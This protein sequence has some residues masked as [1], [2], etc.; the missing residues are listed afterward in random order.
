MANGGLN[1][2]DKKN[3]GHSGT[4]QYQYNSTVTRRAGPCSPYKEPTTFYY[5]SDGTG[6]DSYVLKHN[7]GYRNEYDCKLNGD[8]LFKDSLRSARKSP[9]KHFADP[10]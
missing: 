2:I 9:V 5:Q 3:M 6:R 10:S 7:G 1:G 8:N 4:H